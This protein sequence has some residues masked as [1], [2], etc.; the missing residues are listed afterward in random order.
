[1]TLKVALLNINPG[2]Q[3]D[4]TQFASPSYVDGQWVRFQRSRPRKIGGYNGIFLNAPNISRGMI[5]Q[6]QAGINYLYSGDSNYLSGWQTGNSTASGSG[7]TNI[8]LNNFTADPTNLWQFDI[9]FDPNG[10]NVLNIIAHPGLN[11]TNIDNISPTPV[12]TGTFPYGTLSQVGIFTRGCFTYGNIAIIGSADYRV[13]INQTL[14]GSAV[15]LG[16]TVVANSFG[17]GPTVYSAVTIGGYISGTTLTVTSVV[18]AIY[19]GQPITGSLGVNVTAGTVITAVGTGTGGIGTYTVNNSQTIGSSGTNASFTGG[20]CTVF[21]TSANLTTNLSSATTITFNNNISVSGGTCMLY[22]YLFVYGSNGLIQNSA[23][24]DFTN[25]VSTDANANNVSGTKV[26]KGVPLRGGTTSPAGLFWSLDQLTRVTYSPQTIGTA[27]LYWRYDIISTSI[28]IMSSNCVVEY[29][30]L[31]Y[32]IGIDRF[33]VYNG[34]VQEIINNTNLNYFFDNINFSQRQKVW[35]TKVTRWGEVWWFYPKGNAT[36]CTD[37]IIYNVRDKIWYDAGQAYGAQRSAG[38]FSEVFPYPVWAGN[39]ITG[40][41]IATASVTFGGT[42]Y[43]VGDTINVVGSSGQPAILSVATVSSGVVV[44]LN[45]VTGGNYS[46]SLTGGTLATS[47]RSVANPNAT[48]LTVNITTN[49]FYTLWQHEVGKDQV[50]LTNVDSINSYF[51]T[52]SIGFVGGGLGSQ[53]LINDNKWIRLERFEPDF[54]QSGQMSLTITGKGYAD[55]IN[56]VSAP[57]V[58]TSSTLKIDMKEQRREMRLRITSNDF[59][60]DYQLGNCLLSVDMGDERS[61]GNP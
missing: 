18:G 28:T 22:P 9:G 55:D 39:T 2:I 1:L 43:T 38:V 26:V 60:G 40:Y 32:W 20:P 37:A 21:T 5:M 31:Y 6:S 15:T 48:G 8:T 19:V 7:P 17:A 13:G 30:G 12:L 24:G 4:G 35:G 53:Q 61:T 46:S 58:F 50:Y 3:R 56:I 59:G 47:N 10:S 54:V 36:E 29:D 42:N 41:Q 51:E 57:Y 45:V 23:A 14:S 52:N 44:T 27:T 34:V 11:L 33:F 16:T 25:W 49:S